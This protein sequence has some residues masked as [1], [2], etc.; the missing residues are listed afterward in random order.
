MP[1]R[2]PRGRHTLARDLRSNATDAEIC[3]WQSLRR[4]Q[5][6]WRFHRQRPIGD[7]IVDFYCPAASLVIEVDGSQHFE[8]PGLKRDQGRDAY[9][10]DRGLKVLRF[11]NREVLLQHDA[12]LEKIYQECEARTG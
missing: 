5:L 6:G 9:L 2:Y 7:Y 10:V 8:A 4:R 11:D 12:V 3:L 1:Q